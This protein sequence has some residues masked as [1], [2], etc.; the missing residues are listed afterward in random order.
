MKT[1]ASSRKAIAASLSLLLVAA[2]THSNQSISDAAVRT[3][4]ISAEADQIP[5]SNPRT[6]LP[7]M[8]AN[9]CLAEAIGTAT[10]PKTGAPIAASVD[11]T[12][13]KPLCPTPTQE[14][15]PR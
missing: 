15:K 14:Q 7:Q 12:T 10:D 3:S 9:R 2:C 5:S 13:G 11:P 6:S 1:V 4:A 8:S